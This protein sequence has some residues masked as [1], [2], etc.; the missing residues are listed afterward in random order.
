MAESSRALI[1]V[2]VQN[3]FCEPDGSLAVPHSLQIIP[4]INQIKQTSALYSHVYLTC[5]MHPPTHISFA[6]NHPEEKP[7]SS[8]VLPD[9][10]SIDL[11]PDHCVKGINSC[12][13]RYSNRSGV[14]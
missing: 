2:D 1:I 14:S 13:R 10:Q 5:D 11:W 9:G 7:F 4:V 8:I 3:D 12:V 6:S